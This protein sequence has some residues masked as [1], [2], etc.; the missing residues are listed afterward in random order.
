MA[1]EEEIARAVGEVVWN[2]SNYPEAVQA[3][4]LGQDTAP[5][6]D[7]ISAAVMPLVKRA[8]TQAWQQG[9]MRGFADCDGEYEKA[10]NPYA[11][12]EGAGE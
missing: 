8:Q 11:E 9:W 2:A 1:I 5:L 3:R 4:M 10:D 7:K 6:R 12:N